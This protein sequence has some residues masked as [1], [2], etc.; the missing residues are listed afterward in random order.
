MGNV[1]RGASINLVKV[2]FQFSLYAMNKS[3]VTMLVNFIANI[4]VSLV[5]AIL[6]LFQHLL[7]F[8]F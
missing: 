7:H 3:I 1:S 8:M 4:S 5:S 2:I 6:A